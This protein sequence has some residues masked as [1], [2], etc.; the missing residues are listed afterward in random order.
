MKKPRLLISISTIH[1]T[2]L[3]IVS[4]IV[5]MLAFAGCGQGAGA[6]EGGAPPQVAEP[7]QTP[8]PEPEPAP[9]VTAE[10]GAQQDSK[11]Q[12]TDTAPLKS[13]S[14]SNASQSIF[15]LVLYSRSC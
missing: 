5:S 7:E 9:D 13:C 11:P 14:V 8:E 2:T 1:M 10:D 15:S 4:L 6:P 3:L 12:P